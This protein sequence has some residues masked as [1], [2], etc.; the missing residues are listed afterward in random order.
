MRQFPRHETNVIRFRSLMDSFLRELV[1]AGLA[2]LFDPNPVVF[3]AEHEVGVRRLQRLLNRPTEEVQRLPRFLVR[4]A[5]LCGCLDY[6]EDEPTEHLIIGYGVAYARTTRVTALQHVIGQA[7]SVA[8]PKH[9]E[10]AA[11][12]FVVTQPR[13]ELVVFHNHPPNWLNAIFENLP[14]ASSSDRRVMLRTKYV[15]P[16]MAVKGLLCLGGIRYYVGENGFVREFRV[17]GILQMLAIIAREQDRR[18]QRSPA[19]EPARMKSWSNAQDS[20]FGGEGVRGAKSDGTHTT[21]WKD[22]THRSWDADKFGDPVRDHSTD[23][24]TGKIT[25]HRGED[26]LTRPP[27]LEKPTNA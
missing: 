27:S 20:R 3:K 12:E 17:P 25:E 11:Q 7:G 16:A 14:I 2:S 26:D 8:V 5:F 21:I 4:N 9:V 24:R 18:T 1:D 13:A 10:Q 23:H 22:G 15:Q 19:G 6:T